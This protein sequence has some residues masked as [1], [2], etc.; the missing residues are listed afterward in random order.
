M[1][2]KFRGGYMYPAMNMAFCMCILA[3]QL[4]VLASSVVDYG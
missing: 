2:D 4:G 3:A 1:I